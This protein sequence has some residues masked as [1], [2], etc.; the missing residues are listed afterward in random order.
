MRYWMEAIMEKAYWDS[1]KRGESAYIK[2]MKEVLSE[3]YWD[4]FLSRNE[5]FARLFEQYVAYKLKELKI[6]NIFLTKTKYHTAQY[7]RLTEMKAV[8]PLFDKLLIQMRKHF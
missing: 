7:M 2:R 3:R 8:V 5:I 4:Y 6:K 1:G